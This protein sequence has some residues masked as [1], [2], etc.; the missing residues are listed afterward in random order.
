[1]HRRK[2]NQTNGLKYDLS[3]L[4][5]SHCFSNS[6][7]VMNYPHVYGYLLLVL[8]VLNLSPIL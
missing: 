2:Q 3:E 8:P 7:E 6:C 4:F 5:N 1:M